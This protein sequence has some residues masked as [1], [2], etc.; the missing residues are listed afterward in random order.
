[1][2]E[3]EESLKRLERVKTLAE[4]GI[5]GEKEHAEALLKRLMEKYEIV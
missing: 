1:M 3:R 2:T 5:G 4:R